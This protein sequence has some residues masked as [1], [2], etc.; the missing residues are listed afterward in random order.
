MKLSEWIRLQQIMLEVY[1][2]GKVFI[3]DPRNTEI[4]RK[5]NIYRHDNVDVEYEI[6]GSYLNSK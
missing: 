5:P 1:G 6:F 2:D 4:K 3:E